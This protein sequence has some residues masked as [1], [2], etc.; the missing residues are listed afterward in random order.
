MDGYVMLIH[1]KACQEMRRLQK[2]LGGSQLRN[3][4]RV[5]EGP[6]ACCTRS[7]SAQSLVS[8]AVW[9]PIPHMWQIGFFQAREG[10][11]DATMYNSEEQ[12]KIKCLCRMSV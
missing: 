4:A 10:G 2:D 11:S 6:H 7:L 1:H 3:V 5:V 9:P 8:S 12:F